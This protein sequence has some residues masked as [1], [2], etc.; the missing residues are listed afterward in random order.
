MPF[1]TIYSNSSVE[2]DNFCADA[3]QLVAKELQKPIQYV[4]VNLLLNSA[5][6]FDGSLDTK[7]A[8][9]EMKSIGFRD[10]GALA[11][12]LTDFVVQR[13]QVSPAFVNIQFVDMPASTVAISGRVIG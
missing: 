6:A 7:G 12:S 10:K 9:I 13:L 11:K 1:L 4:V 5:M 8:L 3:A 2:D